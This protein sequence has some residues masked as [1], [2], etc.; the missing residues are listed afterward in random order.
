MT[1]VQTC[2]LP[3]FVFLKD[4]KEFYQ[5]DIIS[6]E[7]EKQIERE[8]SFKQNDCF[9]LAILD[10]QSKMVL[11]SCQVTKIIARDLSGLGV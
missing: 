5:S 4:K 3:I 6:I 8:F 11:D 10:A 1:G 9:V 2:A 7:A